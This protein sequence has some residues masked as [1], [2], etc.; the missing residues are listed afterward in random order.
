MF[1]L[2]RK[3]GHFSAPYIDDSLLKGP[4]YKECLENIQDTVNLVDKLGF[5]VHPE[6]SVFLPTQ[7]IVFLGFILNSIDMTVRL[8]PERVNNLVQLCL[9]I[10]RA[11]TIVIRDFCQLI[12]K[13]VASEPGVQFALL[14]Y[15][16]LEHIK[17]GELRK[18]KGNFDANMQVSGYIKDNLKW[19]IDN[20]KNS[21]KPI[22][23]SEPWVICHSDTSLKGYG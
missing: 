1:S 16:D 17:D 8:T 13:M 4:N 5:T 9:Q 23:A 6:K 12:G 18:N 21:Y 3:L 14:Y 15:K 10:C 11:H 22:H 2:L 20:L 19:W 7:I